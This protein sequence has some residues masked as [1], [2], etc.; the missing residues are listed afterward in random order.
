MAARRSTPFLSTALACAFG[1]VAGAAHAQQ[2]VTM[3]SHWPDEASKRGFVE[4]QVRA[5]EAATP[6]SDV[7]LRKYASV[8]ADE[9]FTPLSFR[10]LRG[11]FMNELPVGPSSSEVVKLSGNQAYAG[12]Q[13]A[14]P[15][16]T[17]R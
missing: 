13:R 12:V 11:A 16:V 7:V 3:W 14:L 15:L 9:L 8:Q 1:L 6:A 5:F 17:T 10:Y 2:T 4:G